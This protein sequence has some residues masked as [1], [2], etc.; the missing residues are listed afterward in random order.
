VVASL[1]GALVIAALLYSLRAA[2]HRAG[3]LFKLAAGLVVLFAVIAGASILFTSGEPFHIEHEHDWEKTTASA[4]GDEAPQDTWVRL[5]AGCGGDRACLAERLSERENWPAV[6]SAWLAASDPREREATIAA[7]DALGDATALDLLAGAAET[8]TDP[9]LRLEAV[10]HLA[11]HGDHRVGQAAV[12]ILGEDLP[13][14]VRDDAHQI[15]LSL[16][17]KDFGY[18]PFADAADNSAALARWTEWAASR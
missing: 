1:G 9:L 12:R 7:L 8:E 5:A 6:A 14:L 13:P 4:G 18:D 15:L 17:G 11:A 2:E 10:R 3:A 16:S